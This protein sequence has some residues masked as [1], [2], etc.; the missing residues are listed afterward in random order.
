V[1]ETRGLPVH[2]AAAKLIST[3]VTSSAELFAIKLTIR[4]IA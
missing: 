1:G 2:L 3:N 4:A